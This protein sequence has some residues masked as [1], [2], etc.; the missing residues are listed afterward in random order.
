MHITHT[1]E[2]AHAQYC[3]NH[4]HAHNNF[5]HGVTTHIL[6]VCYSARFA[7]GVTTRK[8]TSHF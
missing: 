4:A 8:S 5:A 2:H 3:R 1:H 6:Y 7:P